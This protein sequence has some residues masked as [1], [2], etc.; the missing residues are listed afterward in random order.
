MPQQEALKLK[1]VNL[2]AGPGAGKSTTAA[3]LFNLMKQLG[4]KVEYVPEYAK[5]LTYERNYG[6]LTNQFLLAA[7]Q[8][9][10]LRRL[11]G[12]V[13]WAITDSPLPLGIAYCTKEYE[14]WVPEAIEAAY[15]RYDNFDFLVRRTKE[16]QRYGRTQ[17]ESEALAI[18]ISIKALFDDFT[19][20][21][22]LGQA[23]S[24]DG[25]HTA[26]MKIY[27]ELSRGG[28]L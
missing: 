2:W 4:H 3:G 22:T 5:D 23:W 8:D 26:P 21:M 7:V 9:Q 10:R 16:Y 6:N 17:T 15:D 27:T 25:D 13:D 28:Y 24:V 14:D 12:H 20:S 19:E 18:D 1:V 11:E